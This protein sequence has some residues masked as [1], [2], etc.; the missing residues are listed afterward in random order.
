MTTFYDAATWTNI[1]AG[2]DACL[3]V[4]GDY[5][6]PA[7]AYKRFARTRGITVLGGA[8]AAA[9][10]G[11]CDYELYNASFDDPGRLLE[12]TQARQ[13][14]NCRSRV[15]CDRAN[16]ARAFGQVGHVRG[17]C[18]WISTLELDNGKDWTAQA[19]AASVGTYGVTLPLESLWA[20]QFAGGTT[21]KVDTNLLL[22]T[23]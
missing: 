8:A 21:A 3:Y 23:W 14:M 7:A 1:P 12:W 22:G 4:D 11:C 6:V 13:A 15:Y 5:E 20:V 16:A 10:A 18:W 19:L 17:V 2:A 9:K